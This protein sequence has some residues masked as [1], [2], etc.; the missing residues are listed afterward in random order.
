MAITYKVVK[1][2]NPKGADGVD[3]Y[4]GRSVKTSDYSP[5]TKV[6]PAWFLHRPVML[7]GDLHLCRKCIVA[8]S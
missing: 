1:V 2:K 3:F 6:S 8:I 5:W 4:A 7:R